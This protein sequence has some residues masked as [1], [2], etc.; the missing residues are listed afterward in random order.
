M[1]THVNTSHI[2]LMFVRFLPFWGVFLLITIRIHTYHTIRVFFDLLGCFLIILYHTISYYTIHVSSFSIRMYAFQNTTKDR[3]KRI[4]HHFWHGVL[5]FKSTISGFHKITTISRCQGND[6][7][8]QYN[9]Y[10]NS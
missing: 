1:Y 3:T 9:I 5:N 8:I 6:E 7:S 10:A 4:N 2:I